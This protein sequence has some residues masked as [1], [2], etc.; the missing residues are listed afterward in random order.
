MDIGLP[1]LLLGNKPETMKV[2]EGVCVGVS[3]VHTL[4]SFFSL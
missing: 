2:P 1:V 3:T 4:P